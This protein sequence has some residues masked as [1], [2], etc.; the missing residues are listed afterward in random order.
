MKGLL[1]LLLLLG[2]V[3]PRDILGESLGVAFVDEAVSE[4]TAAKAAVDK[5]SVVL[6][7]VISAPV[8]KAAV[9]LANVSMATI[10]LLATCASEAAAV[11][12]AVAVD[13]SIR[14]AKGEFSPRGSSEGTT[15]FITI[16]A[17][18][19]IQRCLL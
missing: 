14:A 18:G 12:A 10:D 19:N 17:H 3:C 5:A 15:A 8:E 4:A 11:E 13:S 2:M 7:S 6:G 9:I 16:P 1:L